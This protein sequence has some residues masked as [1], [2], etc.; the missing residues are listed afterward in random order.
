MPQNS[1]MYFITIG[2]EFSNIPMERKIAAY[3][4]LEIETPVKVAKQLRK[5]FAKHPSNHGWSIYTKPFKP[6]QLFYAIYDCVDSIE[7]WAYSKNIPQKFMND[8]ESK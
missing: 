5:T 7:P 1:E 3:V 4:N 8:T 6:S 2:V